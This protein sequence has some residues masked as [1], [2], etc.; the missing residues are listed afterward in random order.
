MRCTTPPRP[1]LPRQH[2]ALDQHSHRAG[3]SNG[4]N[5]GRVTQPAAWAAEGMLGSLAGDLT[6]T[7]T[8]SPAVTLG[9]P[10]RHTRPHDRQLSRHTRPHD[11]G[12]SPHS[13][14]KRASVGT[15][16]RFTCI[17]ALAHFICMSAQRMRYDL[18]TTLRART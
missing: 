15:L 9:Q 17:C 14:L 12:R 3:E 4:L 1:R 13:E 2:A 18:L 11:E 5:L 10:A 8:Q 6:K 16:P 7:Q